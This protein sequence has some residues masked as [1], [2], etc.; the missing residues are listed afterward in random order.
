[1][2]LGSN[3]IRCKWILKTK[4]KYNN[5]GWIQTFR[6]RL[7]AKSFRQK[8][9]INYFDTYALMACITSIKVLST[10]SSIYNLYVHQM[11][12]KTTLFNGEL[13][14]KMYMEQLEGF[15]L[16]GNE[17]KICKLIKYLYGLKHTPKQWHEKFDFIILE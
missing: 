5:D 17:Y 8:E 15:V 14:E 1:L 9:G 11:D 13:D 10:L 12:V 7:V 4:I 6:E 2:P 16:P 3:A